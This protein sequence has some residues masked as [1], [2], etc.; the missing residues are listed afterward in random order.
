MQERYCLSVKAPHF[1]KAHLRVGYPTS[2]LSLRS[3]S[4][5]K[6]TT[7]KDRDARKRGQ[8]AP[9]AGTFTAAAYIK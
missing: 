2:G 3:P 7:K 1:L 8:R 9:A 6:T 4:Q 5:T